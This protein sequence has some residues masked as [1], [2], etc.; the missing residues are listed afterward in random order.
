MRRTLKKGGYIR[1]AVPD[2]YHVSKV[3]IDTVKPK[4]SGL[5]SDDHKQLFNYE[6]LSKQLVM[7]G[8][9]VEL[10]EW[11]DEFGN[12]N[13]RDW[14]INDGFVT[15]SSRYDE[16]NMINPLSYTSLIIDARK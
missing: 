10:L 8:F 12:F 5:G 16:R 4:G 7:A 11:F 2:G 1:I 6:T 13:F 3:Y 15:R 14:T 9:S